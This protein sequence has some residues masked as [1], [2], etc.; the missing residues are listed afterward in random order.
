[1]PLQ[2]HWTKA[3][4]HDKVCEVGCCGPNWL[5]RCVL[6]VCR[7]VRYR[8]S[9]LHCCLLV[10]RDLPLFVILRKRERERGGG[11]VRGGLATISAFNGRID[12]ISVGSSCVDAVKSL[13][14][15]AGQDHPG[16]QHQEEPK[17]TENQGENDHCLDFRCRRKE[18]ASVPICYRLPNLQS[19]ALCPDYS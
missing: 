7:M 1:M 13:V 17:Q 4:L 19:I 3:G 5:S 2:L 12:S 15:T 8:T 9:R 6:N 18:N 16:N 10:L 11:E 14:I